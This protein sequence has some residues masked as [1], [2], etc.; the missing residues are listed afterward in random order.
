MN[1]IEKYINICCRAFHRYS[2]VMRREM[3]L[4]DADAYQAEDKQNKL[5]AECYLLRYHRNRNAMATEM[6]R[7]INE[8]KELY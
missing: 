7:S 8:M 1:I 6:L 3:G 4:K 2:D 5:L